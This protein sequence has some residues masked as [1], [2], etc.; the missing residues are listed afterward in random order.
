MRTLKMIV[1]GALM[2]ITGCY[3]HTHTTN[4]V[5]VDPPPAPAHPVSVHVEVFYEDMNPYGEWVWVSPYGWVWVPYDVWVGWRPYTHGYWVYTHY[6]WTWVSYWDWGW[7]PFHYGRWVFVGAH[8]WIWVPG[9]VWAPAWVVWRHG[10]GYVGWAPMP[11]QA[12][13]HDGHFY[14]HHYDPDRPREGTS[15]REGSSGDYDPETHGRSCPP[16]HSAA[17]A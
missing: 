10:H 9:H 17:S 14:H 16:D 7:G 15:Y 8:G 12:G 1:I 13:W 2:S 6:G 11:P 3:A 5:E 4:W